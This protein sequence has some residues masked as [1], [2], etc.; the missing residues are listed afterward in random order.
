MRKMLAAAMVLAVT[1]ANAEKLEFGDV[2]Y[3]IKTGELNV[4][5]D[6]NSVYSKTTYTTELET[7]G[8]V[9]EARVGYGIYDNL[10]VY[11]GLDYAFDL[12]TEDKDGADFQDFSSDGF[13]NPM[14]AGNYRYMNQNSGMYNVDFGAVAR[15][16]IM[17]AETG[18]GVAG[19]SEDGTFT[20]LTDTEWADPRSSLELNARIGNKWNEANEWQL[21]AGLVYFN[22]G[23]TD[24]LQTDDTFEIDSSMD[25]FLRATYQYRP[26]QNFMMLLS[27]QGTR[28]GEVEGDVAGSDLTDDS[29]IDFDFDF[30]AK[31]LI[32]DNFIAKFNFAN[33]MNSAYDREIGGATEEVRKRR[34][35]SFGLG[36]EFLF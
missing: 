20:G 8:I 21:A 35:S 11:A 25:L 30:V 13:A 10:N 32:T 24:L 22:D 34:E 28:V 26:V 15:I 17:D 31:Y 27:L 14:I 9:T 18:Y 5:A 19:D 1:S 3:F 16:N 23:E 33:G 36:V 7:R 4:S 2:N 6:V 29:H 12:E